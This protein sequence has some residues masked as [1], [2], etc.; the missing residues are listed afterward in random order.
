MISYEQ[1]T[2]I[3]IDNNVLLTD[4]TVKELRN[5]GSAV[6]GYYTVD[7]A[8]DDLVRHSN[9]NIDIAIIDL[10][11]SECSGGQ[12][13]GD[14]DGFRML[15]YLFNHCPKTFRIIRSVYD[16]YDIFKRVSCNGL[17]DYYV[18]KACDHVGRS[19]DLEK[20]LE[21]YLKLRN[22]DNPT[23]IKISVG[24]IG[25]DISKSTLYFNEI[26]I[27]D[28]IALTAA[29]R[30]ILLY[31]LQKKNVAVSD[32]ELLLDLCGRGLSR[33]EA[34]SI[35]THLSNLRRKFA[36]LGYTN[37]IRTYTSRGHQLIEGEMR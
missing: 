8:I 28:I 32:A 19:G 11:F 2:I 20:A 27:D 12:K 37:F 35:P 17:M 24:A 16:K 3:V 15:E 33:P 18:I 26:I 1:L 9:R 31:L 13:S 36:K 30:A 10:N 23:P 29:E 25:Y 6:F 21:H 4:S 14:P 5:K 34:N 22:F 7:D